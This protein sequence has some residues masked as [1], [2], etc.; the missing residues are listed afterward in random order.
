MEGEGYK[1]FIVGR[2]FWNRK[3]PLNLTSLH[4]NRF[5][6]YKCIY[7]LVPYGIPA[8][9]IHYLSKSNWTGLIKISWCCWR[10]FSG[11]TFFK[12]IYRYKAINDNMVVLAAQSCLTLCNPRD[13]SP[14]GSSVHWILQAR[15]LEW[16][17][18]SFSRGSPW[19]RELNPGLPLCK[20][21]FYHLSHVCLSRTWFN[22]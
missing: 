4:F 5:N 8:Y 12:Y 3:Q 9:I 11:L 22:K 6:N 10:W 14:P 15:I 16:V 19:H 7:N 17:A 21:I 18:I 1:V 20:Q 2:E 13:S